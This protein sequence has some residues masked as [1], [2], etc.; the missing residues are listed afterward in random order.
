MREVVESTSFRKDLKRVRRRGWDLTE[1]RRAVHLLQQ[2]TPLP[3]RYVDHALTGE[4]V[5]QRDLHIKPDWVL[6]YRIRDD[7]ELLRLERTGSHS[8][9]GL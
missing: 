7:I 2:G 6:I 9:L 5:G 3:Q 1:L 8:D 4:R